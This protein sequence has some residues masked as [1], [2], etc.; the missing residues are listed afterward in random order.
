[1]NSTP[2]PES[3]LRS[4][5]LS[6]VL[7]EPVM[8]EIVAALE[9]PPGSKGLDAGCGN[10]FVTLMLAE[11]MGP[12]GQIIGLDREENFLQRART[13]RN[14]AVLA[15]KVSFTPGDLAISPFKDDFFDWALSIDCIGIIQTDPVLLLKELA[16]IVKPGGMVYIGIWSSQ[17]LLPGYPLLEAR[18]NATTSGL[19]PFK[20]TMQP[21]LH[22]MRALEWLKEA[23][24]EDL[25]VRTFVR[26]VQAPL[27]PAMRKAMFDLFNMRWGEGPPELSQEDRQMYR[28]LC[29][30]D[31]PECILDLP[32]YY[33]FFTYSLFWGRLSPT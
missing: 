10:G 32:G 18:L 25:M 12:S 23:G 20:T 29:R 5:E 24:L 2:D 7:R 16:R 19:A 8:Q 4:L 15:R 30:D 13:L 1:M 9:L 27:S 11:A 33:A 3:Y 22:N 31:S 26:D 6:M 21:G 17:M 28:R 14:G